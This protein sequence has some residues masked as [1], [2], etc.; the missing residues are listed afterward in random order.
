MPAVFVI[1]L[2][3]SL[4]RKFVADCGR[5]GIEGRSVL[6]GIGREGTLTLL[7]I[8]NDAVHAFRAYLDGLSAYNEAH[9]VV[10]PYAPIPEELDDE[11]KVVAEMGGVVIRA[12]NGQDGWPLLGKK[13]KPDTAT[14]NLAYARL[15]HALP[16]AQHEETPPPSEYFRLVAEA[17]PRIIFAT[18]V[19]TT[20]D[21]VAHH[22]YDFLRRAVDALVEFAM[23][24]AGGRIDAFFRERGIDHA[25]TGGITTTLTVHAGTENIHTDTSN[26]HLKQGDYTTPQ[27]AARVYYQAFMHQQLTY[28]VVLYAGPHPDK[29]IGWAYTLPIP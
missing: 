3:Q 12:T 5:K 18:G 14:L 8:Q 13:Q 20:C 1:G 19:L 24:G 16:G 15:W 2:F 23:D 27:A 10:F 29:N 17:N 9:V 21:S 4:Q 28:V 6:A 22:R 11:L 26:A 7:P 25:Q